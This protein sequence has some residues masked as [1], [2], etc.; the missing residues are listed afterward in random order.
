MPENLLGARTLATYLSSLSATTDLFT[1]RDYISIFLT[2]MG[3]VAILLVRR[4]PFSVV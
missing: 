1:L 4:R 2:Q 3:H